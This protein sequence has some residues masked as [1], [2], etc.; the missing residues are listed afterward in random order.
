MYDM[1][2]SEM[3]KDCER[4]LRVCLH[5]MLYGLEVGLLRVVST[6]VFGIRGILWFDFTPVSSSLLESLFKLEGSCI[7]ERTTENNCLPYLPFSVL[8]TTASAYSRVAKDMEHATCEFL[9]VT[10]QY[11]KS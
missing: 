6:S 4:G 8:V 2:P 5:V 9:S 1:M 10:S 7:L 11:S 3:N